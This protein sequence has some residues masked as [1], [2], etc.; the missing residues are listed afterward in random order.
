MLCTI[1]AREGPGDGAIV[2]IGSLMGRSTCFLAAGTCAAGRA[3]VVAV[4][5]FRGS[6]EHQKT[7]THPIAA[8]VETGSVLPQ[9]EA[10]LTRFGL[11]ES[12]DIRVGSS[13]EVGSSWN[14]PIRLLFAFHRRRPFR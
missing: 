12:V 6:P 10:N 5:H 7:G 14:G 2:E 11:R 4:D 1:F 8:I 13:V 9:F 3:K